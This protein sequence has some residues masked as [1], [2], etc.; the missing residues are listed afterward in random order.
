LIEI[1]VLLEQNV[2]WLEVSIKLFGLKKLH[3]GGPLDV[4]KGSYL[5]SR[6]NY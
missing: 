4:D 2:L 3:I 1:L 6:E 5:P